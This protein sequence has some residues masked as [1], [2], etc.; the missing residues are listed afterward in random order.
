M[1]AGKVQRSFIGETEKCKIKTY[2]ANND[3]RRICTLRQKVGEID[4]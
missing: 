1:F 4:P 2:D 3:C